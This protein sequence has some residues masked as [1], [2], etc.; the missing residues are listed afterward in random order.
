ML[1]AVHRTDS[2]RKPVRLRDWH[3]PAYRFGSRP[4]GL[5]SLYHHRGK[6]L[7]I[8]A[9]ASCDQARRRHLGLARDYAAR[10]AELRRAA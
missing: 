9:H 4:M 1:H 8:A 6:S 5:N 10:I 3:A 2:H 7:L